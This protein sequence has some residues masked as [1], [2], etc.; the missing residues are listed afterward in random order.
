MKLATLNNIEAE[1][2]SLN[3]ASEEALLDIDIDNSE[4][5]NLNQITSFNKNLYE[6]QEDRENDDDL[7]YFS[8][9]K[10]K[11]YQADV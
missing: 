9:C 6:S 2:G 8:S 5:N 3:S 4:L 7:K 1:N 11:K 10:H